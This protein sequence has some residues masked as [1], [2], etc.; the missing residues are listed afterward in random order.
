MRISRV[1]IFVLI[2]LALSSLTGCSVYNRIIARKNLVDGAKAYKDRKFEIAEKLFADAVARAPKDSNEFKTSQLFLARTLH[3]EF[4]GDRS[5]K[6]KAESAIDVY[7][8]VIERDVNDNSSFKAV[9]N[10]YE[11]LGRADDWKKWVTDRSE[12]AA[13]K[14]EHRAEAFTSLAAKENTCANDISDVEPVKKT[15]NKGGKS[16]FVFTKPAKPEDFESF[17]GCVAK[18]VDYISK[19]VGLETDATKNIGTPDLDKK[20]DAELAKMLEDIKPFESVWSYKTSLTIQNMRLAE[21]EGRTADK[22][23]LKKEADSA[24][25]SFLKLADLRKKIEDKQ[26]ERAKAKEEAEK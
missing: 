15:I 18:G 25:A 8:Q 10:L 7:R 13:V 9:A 3:S 22:D 14:P 26:L 17:K 16:E 5:Q 12:N 4:A 23:N 11:N 20:T 1:G 6:A 19:A 24:K 21:M 2:L